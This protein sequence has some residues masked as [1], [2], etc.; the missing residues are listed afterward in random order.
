[1][2]LFGD[3]LGSKLSVLLSKSPKPKHVKTSLAVSS[4]K[5]KLHSIHTLSNIT[6][7][8]TDAGQLR[9]FKNLFESLS[10]LFFVASSPFCTKH[11]QNLNI[12][13]FVLP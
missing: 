12:S 9:I 7:R 1:M 6:E 5:D 3:S 2:C 8:Q 10:L 11:S 13:V 4:T